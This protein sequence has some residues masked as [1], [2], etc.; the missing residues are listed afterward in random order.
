MPSTKYDR[1]PLCGFLIYSRSKIVEYSPLSVDEVLPPYYYRHM[2]L[3][4]AGD[5]PNNVIDPTLDDSALMAAVVAV[6]ITNGRHLLFNASG[7]IGDIPTITS[8]PPITI[9]TN[10]ITY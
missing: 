6:N 8:L 10:P 9:N 3:P 7:E 5:A 4:Y 1:L 2:D